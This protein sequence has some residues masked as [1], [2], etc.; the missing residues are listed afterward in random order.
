M[1]LATEGTEITEK[2]TDTD[3]DPVIPAK[4]GIHVPSTAE[5]AEVRKGRNSDT[6]LVDS[7]GFPACHSREGG[8][9]GSSLTHTKPRSHEE[10]YHPQIKQISQIQK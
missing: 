10:P 8:N 9:P 2:E 3:M 4:A 5:A 1:I 6:D 7:H